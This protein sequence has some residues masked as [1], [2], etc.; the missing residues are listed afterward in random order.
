MQN[1]NEREEIC[2]QQCGGILLVGDGAVLC[3]WCVE[4]ERIS[5]DLLALIELITEDCLLLAIQSFA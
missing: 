5:I 1:V 2:R 3:N 4:N